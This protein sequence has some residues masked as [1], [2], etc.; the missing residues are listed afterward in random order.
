MA[1]FLL[2][3]GVVNVGSYSTYFTQVYHITQL[4]L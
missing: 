1:P 4:L 3:F 2:N